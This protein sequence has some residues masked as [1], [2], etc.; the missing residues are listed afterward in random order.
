MT[1]LIRA[2][3]LA[4]GVVGCIGDDTDGVEHTNDTA[5]DPSLTWFANCGD[6]VCQGYGGPFP[7]VAACSTEMAGDS[8]SPAGAECDLQNDCNQRLVCASDDPQQQPGGCPISKREVKRDIV[9]LDDAARERLR[10]EAVAMKLATWRYRTESPEARPHL[11]FV[12]DDQPTSPAVRA[13][14]ERVD[15]YGYTSLALAALQAQDAEITE[16]RAEIAALREVVGACDG[17][18][19]PKR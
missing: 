17:Q 12:I 2:A 14:G 13:D 19:P 10:A 1:I 11:G 5:K 4:L 15:L 16:L 6:P 3:F 7:G 8:C 18:E 9:Y